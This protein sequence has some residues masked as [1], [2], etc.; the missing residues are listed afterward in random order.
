MYLELKNVSKYY[1]TEKNHVKVLDDV[2]V[3]I[4]KGEICVILGPSGSGKSTFLN[5]VGALDRCDS[6]NVI[7]NGK[8]I[9]KL[10]KK[11]RS[12]YRRSEFGFIFQ[13]Y[14][15]VP[16]LTVKEN[17]QVCQNLT[18]E[19]LDLDE[20]IDSLGLKEHCD[21]FPSQLS[22]GQQQ[23]CAIARALIK[24]PQLLLCDEPT[25]ALDYKTSKEMLKVM[26]MVNEKY[27]ITM[28]IVT[29]NEA[30]KYMANH[31]IKIRDG[32]IADNYYN[33]TLKKA[34]D[35]EW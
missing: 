24:K 26:Q 16:D 10:N 20:L 22:G 11:Q 33:E 9:A 1:G 6:G 5:I 29:H 12:L 31:V 23:R 32:R 19:S 35:L 14:N 13:F 2:S 28:L 4:E 17:I 8:D 27:G 25:G 34:E 18:K 30:I 21:K 7:I 3:N 15:L